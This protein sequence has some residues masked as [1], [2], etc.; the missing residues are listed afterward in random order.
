[1]YMFNIQ[2]EIEDPLEK[3]WFLCR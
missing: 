3:A 1:M 2:R